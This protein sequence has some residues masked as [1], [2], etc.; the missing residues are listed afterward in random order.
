LIGCKHWRQIFS[1]RQIHF[2]FDL[3]A[4]LADWRLAG[5]GM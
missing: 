5:S 1:H 2:E 4:L 3:F